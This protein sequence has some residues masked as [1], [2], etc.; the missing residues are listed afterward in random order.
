MFVS[1]SIF[2]QD[3]SLAG[4]C[5]GTAWRTASVSP[6]LLP[7]FMIT[8]CTGGCFLTQR[9]LLIYFAR[10]ANF[11]EGFYGAMATDVL[12]WQGRAISTRKTLQ[13]H[14]I[15]NNCSGWFNHHHI[16]IG[17]P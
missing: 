15:S 7:S 14:D 11:V 17:V 12:Q 13:Q 9:D 1:V 5:S 16:K 6:L 10:D 4:L 2:R 8:K 3:A